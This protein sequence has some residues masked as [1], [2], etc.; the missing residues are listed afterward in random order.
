MKKTL[1]IALSILLV[2]TLFSLSGC[3]G[4]KKP[5]RVCVDIAGNLFAPD[6]DAS[7]QGYAT[8]FVELAKSICG[9]E[10]IELEYVPASGS[11][12]E[13][14]MTRIRTEMMAGG[15]PDVF[16]M[17]CNY[18]L[19]RMNQVENRSLFLFPEKAMELGTFL[20]LDKYLKDARFMEWDKLTP[21]VMAAGRTEKGQMILP[22]S[23]EIPAA[24]F[25]KA[26]VPNMP[27]G[28][29]TWQ[30]LTADDSGVLKVAAS[31]PFANN[32]NL[33]AT[34]LGKLADYQKQEL[35]FTEEELLQRVQ[36]IRS[37]SA[38]HDAL[39]VP[40]DVPEHFKTKLGV[41]FEMMNLGNSQSVESG[42][43]L[44]GLHAISGMSTVDKYTFVTTD[45]L[46]MVPV[47]CD[48]G[49]VSAVVHAYG[50]IN[51][52]TKRPEDAFAVLDLL[53]SHE[54]QS[55][56]S[57]YHALTW[58]EVQIPTYEG[59]MTED[60]PIRMEYGETYYMVAEN[61][62]ALSKVRDQ[63]SQVHFC[64]TL[65]MELEELV[66]WLVTAQA[67][68]TYSDAALEQQVHEFYSRMNL[69]FFE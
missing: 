64:S 15:G 50:A 40:G 52:N 11:D 20:P 36:E 69:E 4:E 6:A 10:D 21:T 39:K 14:M 29:T 18:Q 47:Y 49:G 3:S 59:L 12:R 63:I 26:D 58:D 22:L 8:S 56:Y 53:L 30:D 37:L 57:I 19:G 38:W 65:D 31:L 25:R 68:S 54:A 35:L 24:F 42:V 16:I 34:S 67:T 27:D 5:L 41:G 7:S 45:P 55:N 51:A 13:A 32:Y 62:E 43:D 23:Y 66:N 44:P 61:Y 1:C 2:L 28:D 48:D 17:R 33:L 60:D 46:T 9:I